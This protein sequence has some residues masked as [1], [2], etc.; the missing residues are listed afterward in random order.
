[1]GDQFM[2]GESSEDG[3]SPPSEREIPGALWMLENHLAHDA[4]PDE[5]KAA[6]PLITEA[7]RE[8]AFAPPWDDVDVALAKVVPPILFARVVWRMRGT[9]DTAGRLAV[10]LEAVATELGDAIAQT[11]ERAARRPDD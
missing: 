5:W 10:L 1:M 2:F 9:P 7:V 8:V 4:L 3:G 11:R 6:A